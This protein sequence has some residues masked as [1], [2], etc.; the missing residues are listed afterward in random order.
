ML[1][2]R[3]PWADLIVRGL[4]TIE[5]RSTDTGVRG[6]VYIY[7]SRRPSELPD[8]AA[9]A[10]KF[11]LDVATLPQGV[12]VGMAELVES[13]PAKPCDTAGALVTAEWLSGRFVW[14]FAAPE[15]FAEPLSVRFQPFGIWFYPF[16]R[17]SKPRS[18]RKRPSGRKR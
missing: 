7:A 12:I 16:Q 15:R 3:Q 14:R 2:V 8:A 9:A 4:K 13:R 6:R 11:D 17:R 5:V 18:A 1:G 10:A